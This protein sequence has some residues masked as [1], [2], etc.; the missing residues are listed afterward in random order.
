MSYFEETGTLPPPFNI[1]PKPKHI[2]KLLG[3]RK[4]DKFN[5][6]STKVYFTFIY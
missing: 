2:F 1:F 4:K 5:R 6:M 3:I